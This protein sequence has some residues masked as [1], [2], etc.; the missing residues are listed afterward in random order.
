MA[1]QDESLVDRAKRQ[2]L[3][4]GSRPP[5]VVI[6]EQ[7]HAFS[8]AIDRLGRINWEEIFIGDRF[9]FALAKEKG[10]RRRYKPNAESV[11][12]GW[13]WRLAREFSRTERHQRLT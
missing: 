6:L 13:W 9:D 12:C 2:R 1:Q 10:R 8:D 4:Q 7:W 11:R 3:P 5:A